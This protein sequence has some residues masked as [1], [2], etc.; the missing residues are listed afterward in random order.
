M[1]NK[2][3]LP[4]VPKLAPILPPN[5][6]NKQAPGNGPGSSQKAAIA[7]TAASA[8]VMPVLVLSVGGYYLDKK[9]KDAVPWFAILGRHRRHDRRNYGTG[10]NYQKTGR[11]NGRNLPRSANFSQHASI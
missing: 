8:F 3:D 1:A 7:T 5:P 9:I 2:D 4:E 6:L 11:I 10:A